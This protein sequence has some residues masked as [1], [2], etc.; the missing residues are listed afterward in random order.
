MFNF[1]KERHIERVANPP[2]RNRGLL[3]QTALASVLALS[4]SLLASSTSA[5]GIEPMT[6]PKASILDHSKKEEVD[7]VSEVV[8]TPSATFEALIKTPEGGMGDYTRDYTLLADTR[9]PISGINSGF[10]FRLSLETQENSGESRPF[11]QVVIPNWSD[12]LSSHLA[13]RTIGGQ[14][15]EKLPPNSDAHLAVVSYPGDP[16][17]CQLDLYINGR[18]VRSAQRYN[19]G[20]HCDIPIRIADDLRVGQPPDNLGGI[21]G[22]P[23]DGQ[24]RSFRVSNG[25]R[26]ADNFNSP[27]SL[28]VDE[29]T[30]V[31]ASF[32]N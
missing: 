26:Y 29:T 25:V 10:G 16:N 32:E 3:R 2:K 30:L 7:T 20:S 4:A 1:N 21:S 17:N 13:Y 9:V 14:S 22:Y 6:I 27:D 19:P 18:Y 15:T 31:A 24:V 12:V 11:F 5:Q 23:F 28:E 8:M